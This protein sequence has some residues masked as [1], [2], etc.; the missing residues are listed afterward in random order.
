MI[1]HNEMGSRVESIVLNDSG[2]IKVITSND[3]KD[4]V[5]M[6]DAIDLM[7]VAFSSFSGQQCYVPPRSVNDIPGM[8]LTIILKPAYMETLGRT[9]IKILSQNEGNRFTDLPTIT[10]IILLIDADTG[11]ILALMDGAYIT[12]LRTGAASGLASDYLARKDAEILAIFGCGAQG[13]TQ[14]EA[15][16]AVRNI[17]RVYVY[18]IDSVAADIYQKDMRKKF[19]IE[20]SHT[21]DPGH[22]KEVDIICTSTNSQSPLF[23]MN[24]IKE[25]VHIN[26]IGSYK[27]QMQE[28]DPE[29]IKNSRLY[30][31]SVES[32]VRESGDI[33]VPIKDGQISEDHIIGEIGDVVSGNAEGRKSG[34]DITVFKSVGIAIQDL[35]VA[36]E[37]YQRLTGESK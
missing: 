14:L 36:N 31:D 29:I 7:S 10:G 11:Q 8:D 33:I 24:H 6:K 1:N 26:A 19:D 30:V 35:V 23:L 12:E 13:R 5:G 17:K 21:H 2:A 27:P 3:V 28:I 18:D 37:A 4:V 34:K 9:G 32:C 15:V 25:G 22:L 20:I 16:A